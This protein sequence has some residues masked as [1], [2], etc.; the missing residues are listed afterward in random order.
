VIISIK[1]SDLMKKILLLLTLVMI[2][3]ASAIVGHAPYQVWPGSFQWG[4]YIFPNGSVGINTLNP[5]AALHVYDD[6]II[7]EDSSPEME[8]VDFNDNRWW[9]IENTQG[10]FALWFT[11]DSGASWVNK[12]TIAEDGKVGLGT[13]Y[14]ETQLHV[15]ET[16]SSSGV[17]VESNFIEL[18]DSSA[19][20]HFTIS[21]TNDTWS[22]VHW[23]D[24]FTFRFL[25]NSTGSEE[26]KFRMDNEGRLVLSD[27]ATV[28][29]R[30]VARN[31]NYRLL[32]YGT[33]AKSSG[34]NTWAVA[35]DR[36]VKRDITDIDS[37]LDKLLR[38]RGVN[39]FWKDPAEH[40]DDTNIQAG[41]IAQEVEEVFPE[42]VS[43]DESGLLM[44]N[45]IGYEAY[46]IEA[47][48]ELKTETDAE[49][50]HLRAQ[51]EL[52]RQEICIINPDS[53]ICR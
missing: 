37:S 11:N 36:R 6:K 13:L 47:I 21:S 42:W 27:D 28:A 9:K 34:G 18:K 38:L 50:A 46:V 17:T 12:F 20:L 15:V 7:V 19:D 26:N 32:I 31:N 24:A 43:G 16:S 8:F 25:D 49:L 39:F 3:L 22:I 52:L 40:G 2:P 1:E 41:F 33:A 14:P 45:P 48:R 5:Q 51:N 10:Y 23:Y 53:E 35:S 44:F 29:Q 4:D 30:N